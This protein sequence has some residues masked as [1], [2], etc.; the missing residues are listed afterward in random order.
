MGA[1][2]VEDWKRQGPDRHQHLKGQAEEEPVK[3][4][5]NSRIRAQLLSLLK[6]FQIPNKVFFL[7]ASHPLIMKQSYIHFSHNLIS[8][9]IYAT[10]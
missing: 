9:S 6:R 4:K 1:F 3:T 8:L 2:V 10:I 7:F 5:Q